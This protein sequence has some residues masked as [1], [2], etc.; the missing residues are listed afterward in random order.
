MRVR[1]LKLCIRDRDRRAVIANVI[2]TPN[3]I[4]STRPATE[5]SGCNPDAVS[6][7]HLDVYKR[8]A[9]LAPARSTWLIT[10]PPNTSPL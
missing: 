9:V 1:K 5:A 6:Y 4:S 8:Q 3:P 7:T 10:Q 2:P